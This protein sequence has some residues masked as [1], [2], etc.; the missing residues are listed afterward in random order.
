M[1]VIRLQRRGRKGLAIYRVVVQDKRTHPSKEKLVARLGSYNP[2][3][4]ELNID[5]EEAQKFVDNGAQPSD[6]VIAL[7]EKSG[8]KLPAWV[9]KV[10]VKTKTLRNPEKLRKNQ[11]KEEVVKTPSEVEEAPEETQEE[12]TEETQEVATEPE[13]TEEASDEA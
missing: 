3:T 8:V 10:E 7:L 11:P 9:K 2:H 6:R 5:K 1:L 4:K 12:V 13:T